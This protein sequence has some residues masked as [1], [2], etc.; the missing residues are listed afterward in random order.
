MKTTLKKIMQ[1]KTIKSKNNNIFEN[2]RRPY[3]FKN[4]DNL[5]FLKNEDDLK[6]KMQ[7]KTIKSKQNNNFENGRRPETNNSTKN[8]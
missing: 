5:N 7:P 1:P 4:E 3:F 8:N 2:G 6:K